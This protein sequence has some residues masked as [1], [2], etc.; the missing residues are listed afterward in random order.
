MS[1][2][3]VIFC[4]GVGG[5]GGGKETGRVR[6]QDEGGHTYDTLMHT[7]SLRSK[8]SCCAILRTQDYLQDSVLYWKAFSVYSRIRIGIKVKIQKSVEAQY[9]SL[10]RKTKNGAVDGL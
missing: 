4:F 2:N 10:R 1:E 3:N 6:H 9:G 8:P 5:G 7:G